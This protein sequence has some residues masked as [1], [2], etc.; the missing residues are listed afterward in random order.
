MKKVYYLL[1][2][3]FLGQSINAQIIGT[4]KLAPRVGSLAVGPTE[5]DF[6]WWSSDLQAVTDRACL[7]DDSLTF[8][9]NGEV[10]HYMDNLTWLEEW[11]GVPTATCGFP[12]SPHDGFG[13]T[14][15][16]FT[17][18]YDGVANTLTLNGIG[19]HL[20]LPK[21]INGAEITSNND[22]A[23]SI[24]YNISFSNNDNTMTAIISFGTGFWKF[25]YDRTDALEITNPNV[26]F[27][28]DMN[29]YTGTIANGVYVNGSFNAWCGDCNPMTNIGNN[30]WEV[31]LPLPAGSIEYKFTVDGWSAFE[32]FATVLP[33]ID[34][35]A[36][37]FNNRFFSFT[38]DATIP[39]V[40][41]N[42][43]DACQTSSLI[44]N[45][46]SSKIS[47]SPNPASKIIEI[48]SSSNAKR[49]QIINLAG[50]NVIDVKGNNNTKNNINVSSLTSG[51]Y[52]VNV[53]TNEGTFIQ[54][55]V[56]E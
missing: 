27:S 10:T 2:F 33:C 56:I 37:G 1:F 32:E 12:L 25:V 34:N 52:L 9:A 36:D 7:F 49:I 51:V 39:T 28:V 29:Q 8:D 20:G 42:S 19:A 44:E 17:Y 21:V 54:K 43:C 18:V 4:W 35:V 23:A 6:S 26:T 45:N 31:T 50:T 40:C 46:I 13:L 3:A 16:P 14:S 48:S 38:A 22:A 47:I 41:Y 53:E 30:I 5:T 15:D 55:L 24:V 11:Q